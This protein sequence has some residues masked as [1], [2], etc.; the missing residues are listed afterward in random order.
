MNAEACGNEPSLR[1]L[2][3]CAANACRSVAGEAL[4]RAEA[5]R[6]GLASEI[7]VSS[8]GI[9][10]TPGAPADRGVTQALA[11]AGARVLPGGARELTPDVV[12]EAD[13]VLVATTAMRIEVVRL[14]VPVAER[15]F[16]VRRAA[17]L[18]AMVDPA[19]LPLG[20]FPVRVAELLAALAVL[21]KTD[22]P[23]PDDDLGDPSGGGSAAYQGL[24]AELSTAH[25][26]L[27]DLLAPPGA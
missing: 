13:L 16:T 9:W 10:A 11:E 7:S 14:H 20:P 15:T 17:R 21:A 4:L 2:Y 5:A 23:D 27:L 1:V 8:A 26:R 18:L 24:F 22:L 3:V 19:L 12:A 6:Y 25:S